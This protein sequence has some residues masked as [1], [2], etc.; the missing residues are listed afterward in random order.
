MTS[1][2]S[3]GSSS[4]AAV[5]FSEF[6]EGV[7]SAT[8]Q[9]YAGQSGS[10]V[11]DAA[12]F[13]QMRSYLLT[14]YQTAHVAR[15]FTDSGGGVFDCIQQASATGAAGACP[16]GSIPTQRVTLSDLVRFPTLQ[17]FLSKGPDGTGQIPLPPS[18][19]A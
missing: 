10:K 5:P 3:S 19:T 17:Q 1:S 16:A 18:T 13:D 2:G 11:R 15:T 14:R 12:A 7:T 9:Q 4:T 6:L 8:Y